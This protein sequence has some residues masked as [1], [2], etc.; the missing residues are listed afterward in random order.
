MCN[1]QRRLSRPALGYVRCLPIHK[2]NLAC[3]P[4]GLAG[5]CTTAAAVVAAVAVAAVVV[6]A[7]AA[8]TVII[9]AVVV[10]GW[11]K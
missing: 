4:R 3:R 5:A 1:L 10:T 8:I 2:R 11:F 7:A 9:I 6:A